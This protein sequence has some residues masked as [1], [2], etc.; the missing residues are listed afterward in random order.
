[1]FGNANVLTMVLLGLLT[2]NLIVSLC[3]PVL[4]GLINY[5]FRKDYNTVKLEDIKERVFDVRGVILSQ[6][7][8]YL[9]LPAVVLA[10]A[11]IK[12]VVFGREG[13]IIDFTTAFNWVSWAVLVILSLP[14][15]RWL[16]DVN[17]NLKVKKETGDSEKLREMESQIAELKKMEGK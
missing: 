6:I 3:Y 7:L 9:L 2:V 13:F 1:M 4:I 14:F 12:A 8:I 16:V 10:I 11:M 5:I 15:T 17:R